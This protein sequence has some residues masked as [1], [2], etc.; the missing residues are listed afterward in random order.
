MKKTTR[1][2]A[3]LTALLLMLP[4]VGCLV[5]KTDRPNTT[6]TAA[7]EGSA[8]DGL[9]APDG[10]Q[11]DGSEGGKPDGTHTD[12]PEGDGTFDIDAVAIELG[13]IQITAGE[14]Q[15]T[16]DEFYSY[17]A[18]AYGADEE[19]LD[20][21]LRMAEESVIDYYLPTWQAAEQ[22][23]TLTEEQEE[24]CR[25]EA[26]AAVDEERSGFLQY[27]A[28]GEMDEDIS[29]LTQDQLD[30]SL[31]T[32]NML[33]AQMYGEGYDFE[34]FLELR[35]DRNLSSLRNELFN[36]MLQDSVRSSVVADQSAVDAQYESTLA[37]QKEAF[38][39]DPSLFLDSENGIGDKGTYPVC[40]YVPAEAARL[41]FILVYTADADTALTEKQS[42]MEAL[43]AEYGALALNGENAERQAA[44]ETE[45]AALKA[46]V[47]SLDENLLKEAQDKIEK[48]HAALTGGMTFADAMNTYNEPDDYGQC[49]FTMTVFLGESADADALSEAA[50]ALAPG[51][52]S[53]PILFDDAYYIIRLVEKLP[54]GVIDRA[55][56][57]ERFVDSLKYG[58]AGDT[59][60]EEQRDAW[61]TEAKEIAVYHHDT[62]EML[63]NQ[64]LEMYDY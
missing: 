48:A 38:D 36:N 54:A 3:F 22:G 51:E 20:Q 34:D 26:Q 45:Y 1:I 32:I 52:Y 10:L 64:Y 23:I 31:E 16:F 39:G 46:E 30:S 58:E 44:I 60:W 14:L 53:Q 24:A 37:A 11:T 33:L 50:A 9:H 4:S 15:E 42:A 13:D 57:E 19:M 5:S 47:E 17:F 62:Y 6:E 25:L 29:D 7:P 8:D 63:I 59:L 40:L 56:V 27:Y 35:Y 12:D 41:E 28:T 21:Y 61:L 43:E 18:Y 2:L 49:E 55:S